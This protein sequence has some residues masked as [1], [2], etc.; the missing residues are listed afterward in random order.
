MKI[1]VAQSAGYKKLQKFSSIDVC[2]GDVS[3]YEQ[4]L[5]RKSINNTGGSSLL[6]YGKKLPLEVMQRHVHKINNLQ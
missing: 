6:N 2:V 1:A 5:A 4:L 3:I